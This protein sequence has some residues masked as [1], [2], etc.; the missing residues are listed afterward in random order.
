MATLLGNTNAILLL[1]GGVHLKIV[2]ERLGH[3]NI[4]ITLDTY[5]HVLS[6]FQERMV[7]RSSNPASVGR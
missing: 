6:E 3:A 4:G 5:S 7:A 1:K 2:I